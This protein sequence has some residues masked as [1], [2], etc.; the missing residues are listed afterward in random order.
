MP[1]SF[2]FQVTVFRCQNV[3][4]QFNKF[5]V[6]IIKHSTKTATNGQVPA[7]DTTPCGKSKDQQVHDGS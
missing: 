5:Q 4:N 3:E 2:S 6:S 1:H 7:R